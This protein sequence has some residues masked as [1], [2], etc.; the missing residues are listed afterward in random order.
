MSLPQ[1]EPMPKITWFFVPSYSP[2]QPLKLT[3][4]HACLG[5]KTRNEQ[6]ICSNLF[7][8]RVLARWRQGGRPS[9]LGRSD[10]HK[11][12]LQSHTL[13]IWGKGFTDP[14]ELV[15]IVG[16]RQNPRTCPSPSRSS[17]SAGKCWGSCFSARHLSL[18][19]PGAEHI[20]GVLCDSSRF[21]TAT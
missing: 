8:S 16:F 18:W 13:I 21:Y 3:A 1:L 7:L 14:Q 11:H 6:S 20:R 15:L 17:P 19:I 10:E 2:T 5:N 4:P 12:K 9:L